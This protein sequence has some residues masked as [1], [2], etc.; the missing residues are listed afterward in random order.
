MQLIKRFDPPGVDWSGL[1]DCLRYNW[2]KQ[3]HI[4]EVPFYYIEYG[5][6]QLGAVAVWRNYMQNPEQALDQYEAALKLG[7]TQTIGKI[8][9]AAGIRFDFSTGYVRELVQFVKEEISKL[10]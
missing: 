1:E 7:N 5:M 3:L 9:E 4:F 10:K 2:Q 8:Y 6:A